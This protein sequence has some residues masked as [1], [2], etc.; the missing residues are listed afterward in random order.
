MFSSSWQH[1]VKHAVETV[2]LD[3]G[4]CFHLVLPDFQRKM[5]KLRDWALNIY[6]DK[7]LNAGQVI[8]LDKCFE[9]PSKASMHKQ[10]FY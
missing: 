9:T 1:T 5:G 3:G 6:N 4:G 7:T 8:R 2:V 10:E